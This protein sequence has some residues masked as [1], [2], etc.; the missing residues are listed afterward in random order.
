[1]QVNGYQHYENQKYKCNIL[2]PD[3][4]LRSCEAKWVNEQNIYIFR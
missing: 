2:A 3:D 1:M 4:T